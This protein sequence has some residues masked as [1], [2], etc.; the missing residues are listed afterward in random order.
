M[1]IDKGLAAI[2]GV[3]PSAAHRDDRKALI[4]KLIGER[5]FLDDL[6][7]EPYWPFIRE[8]LHE[9]GDAYDWLEEYFRDWGEGDDP[10]AAARFEWERS[11]GVK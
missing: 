10:N 9:W 5:G 4:A 6:A 11:R 3:L 2:S 8:H 7:H 1:T